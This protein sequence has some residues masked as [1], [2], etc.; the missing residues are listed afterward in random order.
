MT[1][2][3]PPPTRRREVASGTPLLAGDKVCNRLFLKQ[4]PYM[5]LESQSRGNSV[6]GIL[7]DGIVGP[8]RYQNVRDAE[9][10]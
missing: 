2:I 5:M 4:V 1:I 8:T 3:R 6:N 10:A 7:I 9:T